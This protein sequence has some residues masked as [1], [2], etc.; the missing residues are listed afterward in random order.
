MGLIYHLSNT[1]PIHSMFMKGHL[2]N[3]WK[4]LVKMTFSSALQ[5]LNGFISLKDLVP[6][7]FNY[8]QC[9]LIALIMRCIQPMVLKHQTET[10]SN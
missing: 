1:F 10:A 6:E 7:W 2:S 3:L 9:M 5:C 8:A 4:G